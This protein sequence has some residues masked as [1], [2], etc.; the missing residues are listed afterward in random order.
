MQ[1][2]SCILG[3]HVHLPFHGIKF[4]GDGHFQ[5]ETLAALGMR[6][7]LGHPIGQ[8]CADPVPARRKLAVIHTNGIH[9]VHIDY[10]GCDR[11]GAAGN[12][13]QQLLRAR[14]FPATDQSPMTCTT[15][16]CL[17]AVH[18]Q[19]VQSKAGIYDLYTAIERLTDNTGLTPVRVR[20]Q[21]ALLIIANDSFTQDCYKAFLRTVR[22]WKHLK[23]LKRAGRGHD[24]TGVMGT[25]Q[26][27]L[28]V[29]CPA[30]PWPGINL[31]DDWAEAPEE[32]R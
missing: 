9:Q 23:M 14:L 29:R 31:P 6:I 3:S 18:L 28:V 27:E 11:M 21:F 32:R 19:N 1:C 13:R 5:R 24:A 30:C 16:T 25:K 2:Q 7:Q 8:R 4:W 22:E 17:E 15:F 26:G 10:C 20:V 12:E